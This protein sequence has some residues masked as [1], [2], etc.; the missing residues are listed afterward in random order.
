MAKY[1]SPQRVGGG[2]IATLVPGQWLRRA[3]LF[4]CALAAL[5]PTSLAGLREFIV[6][7][8]TFDADFLDSI[9]LAAIPALVG[10]AAIAYW[11]PARW[12][13]RAWTSWLLI[14]P[15]VGLVVLGY[16]LLQ[17]WFLR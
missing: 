4:C 10:A 17:P 16:S 8:A 11:V 9:W 1:P 15:I 6:N 12:A 2:W 14:T 3:T 5:W 7:W 13:D